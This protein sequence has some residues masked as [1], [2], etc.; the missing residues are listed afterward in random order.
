[1]RKR[2]R[3]KMLKKAKNNTIVVG[4]WNCTI[5]DVYND[6]RKMYNEAKESK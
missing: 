6:L 4:S 1:M 2:L 3:K 5:E